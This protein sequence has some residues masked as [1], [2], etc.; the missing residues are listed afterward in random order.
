MKRNLIFV[1]CAILSLA[2]LFGGCTVNEDSAES[3]AFCETF[4]DYVI[5]NDYDAAYSMVSHVAT[6]ED[7]TAVWNEMRNVL[8]NSKSYETEQTGWYQRT[9]NGVTTTEVLFEVVSDDGKVCQIRIYTTNGVDGIAG[10]HFLDST[11]FIQETEYFSIVNIFLIIFSLVC[12]AFT[13]WMLIDCLKRRMRYKVLWVILTMCHLGFSIMKSVSSFNFQFEFYFLF[14]I[15]RISAD[16]S[17]LAVL[18]AVFFPVG[19]IIYFFMRKRLTISEEIK[20]EIADESSEQ[21]TEETAS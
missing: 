16:P 13:V 7:F 2:L 19:A 11:E 18:V 14:P 20:A 10:L 4:L 12:L 17:A 9:T 6:Q 8:Q 5:Q 1:I 21:S 15:S 3:L